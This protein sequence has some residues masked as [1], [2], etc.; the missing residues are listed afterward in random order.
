[1]RDFRLLGRPAAIGVAATLLI[2]SNGLAAEGSPQN[3]Q[4]D[5]QS[6]AP[7]KMRDAG[8]RPGDLVRIRSG[9]PLM[10]VQ[11]VQGDQVET[12]WATED[13][14]MA[15]GTFNVAYLIK[16]EEPAVQSEGRYVPCPANVEINGRSACLD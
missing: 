11:A 13:G 15:S 1:M 16:M 2:G 3:P 4:G 12:G 8:L 10:T 9:G 6:A 14:Q 5:H 7:D